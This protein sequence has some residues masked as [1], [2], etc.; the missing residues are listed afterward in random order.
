MNLT[1]KSAFRQLARRGLEAMLP[2]RL[3]L[4]R[5]ARSVGSVCLTFDDGPHPEHTP[6]LLD[7][8]RQEKIPATFFLIGREA[9]KYP[10]LVRRMAVDGHSVGSHSYSHRKRSDLSQREMVDEVVRGRD[11]LAEILGSSS[12]LF[13]PPQGK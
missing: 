1:V 4:V 13:R 7:F 11:V 9:E 3:F 2:R 12:A 5:G 10:D 8:L 6:K